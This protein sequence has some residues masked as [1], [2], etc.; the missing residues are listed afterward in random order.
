MIALDQRSQPCQMRTVQR[1]FAADGQAHAVQGQ[2]VL[3]ADQSQVVV[4]RP[5]GDHVVFGVHF[6]KTDVG[7]GL[8]H[9][10]EVLVLEPQPGPA[11]EAGRLSLGD[12]WQ[13]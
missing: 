1:A 2:R 5:A 8:K 4:K 13:G 7:G 12:G 3:L 9:F 11:R 10:A 6:K